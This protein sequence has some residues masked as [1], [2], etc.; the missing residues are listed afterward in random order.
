MAKVDRSRW[1]VIEGNEASGVLF[2]PELIKKLRTSYA[3]GRKYRMREDDM[4]LDEKLQELRDGGEPGDYFVVE[5]AL[6]GDY[7]EETSA[8]KVETLRSRIGIM[9]RAQDWPFRVSGT[10]R[11]SNRRAYETIPYGH[12][13]RLFLI[14]RKL[15]T[16]V[17]PTD[18]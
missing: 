12:G 5:V 2:T 8:R 3:A 4:E 18:I 16:F 9:V 1:S 17:P 10:G 14:I 11:R 13:E 7:T 15:P 6:D